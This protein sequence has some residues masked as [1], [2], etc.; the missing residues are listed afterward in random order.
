MMPAELKTQNSQV[1]AKRTTTK[2][3]VRSVLGLRDV[4]SRLHASS[5][6]S[7]DQRGQIPATFHGVFLDR[8]VRRR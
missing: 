7:T 8:W 1:E 4:K 5:A 2:N 3:G 6:R